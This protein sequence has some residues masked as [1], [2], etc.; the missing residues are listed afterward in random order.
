MS[1]HQKVPSHVAEQSAGPKACCTNRLEERQA[2]TSEKICV[3]VNGGRDK[4]D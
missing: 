2:K 1:L 4:P 3:F